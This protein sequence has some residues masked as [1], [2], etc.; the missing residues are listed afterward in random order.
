MLQPFKL[1]LVRT[2]Q[3]KILIHGQKIS[4]IWRI[5]MTNPILEQA[6]GQWPYILEAAGIEPSHL[7]N[8]HGPC[9]I[10]G[11]KD[12][13]RFDDK[14]GRGTFICTQCGAGTGIKLLQLYREYN[15]KDALDFIECTLNGYPKPMRDIL[16]KEKLLSRK[17]ECKNRKS[18]RNSLNYVWSQSQPI[19]ADDP[20]DRYLKSR[21]I[22]LEVFPKSLRYHSNLPYYDNDKII[23]KFPAML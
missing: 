13:F 6:H 19:T 23:G 1:G 14:E 12:R 9:P 21:S 7:Q 17:Q 18:R 22:K 3:Q 2:Y 11:G 10:C 4:S 8:K 20:V 5:K 15:F 16:K